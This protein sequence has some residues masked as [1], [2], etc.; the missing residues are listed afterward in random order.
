MHVY[1]IRH[2]Q[3]I[4]N[5]QPFDGRNEN[6]ILTDKGQ[7]QAKRLAAWAP[8]NLHLDKIY[9]SPMR[10]A[11]QTAEALANAL[12]LTPIFDDRLREVGNNYP[13]GTAFPDDA[14]PRYFADRWGSLNPY[15]AITEQGEN[16]MQFRARIGGFV[17]WLIDQYEDDHLDMHIGVVCH[18]GVIE[19]VFE[20]VFQKGPWSAVVVT[21][22]NTGITHLEYHPRPNFPDWWVFYHNRVNHLTSDLIT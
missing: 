10:R 2:G 8:E 1:L 20:H 21:T 12:A 14:L 6:S 19:G 9:A 4:E 22:N 17:E 5:T 13:N 15:D 3:S 11:R 16:W 18:G 7:E